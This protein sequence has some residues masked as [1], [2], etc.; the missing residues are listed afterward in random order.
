MDGV[1]SRL[2]RALRGGGDVTVNGTPSAPGVSVGNNSIQIGV[3]QGTDTNIE[4]VSYS[5]TMTANN[6]ADIEMRTSMPAAKVVIN[7]TGQLI[8]G[9]DLVTGSYRRSWR[10]PDQLRWFV[11]RRYSATTTPFGQ[12]RRSQWESDTRLGLQLDHAD[13]RSGRLCT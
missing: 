6:Y 12:E 5:G 13:Q 1:Y 8:T 10:N 2:P 3:D 4:S 7:G 9:F 11:E